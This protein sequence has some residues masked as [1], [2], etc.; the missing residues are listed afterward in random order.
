VI[1]SI[2]SRIEE[3]RPAKVPSHTP[4]DSSLSL[5]TSIAA[6]LPA[7]DAIAE[8]TI[9]SIGVFE[10]SGYARTAGDDPIAR[11]CGDDRAEKTSDN[12]EIQDIANRTAKP[13]TNQGSDYR[14]DE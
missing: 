7:S 11:D 1:I 13:E 2:A 12:S 14:A 6:E 3:N 5:A 8:K 10:S 9:T 4:E